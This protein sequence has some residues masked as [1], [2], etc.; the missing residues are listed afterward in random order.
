MEPGQAAGCMGTK[1]MLV[2]TSNQILSLLPSCE[3]QK[4][5][6]TT[7]LHTVVTPVWQGHWFHSNIAWRYNFWHAFVACSWLL[8]F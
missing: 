5:S 2:A 7:N 8:M 3:A 1:E 4:A 6:W